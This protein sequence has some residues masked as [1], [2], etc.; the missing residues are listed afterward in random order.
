MLSA[1]VMGGAETGAC[2]AFGA[3]VIALL[4]MAL[5]L[6][7]FLASEKNPPL[8]RKGKGGDGIEKYHAM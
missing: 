4:L 6:I 8:P 5:C 1:G 2:D 7:C 3:G